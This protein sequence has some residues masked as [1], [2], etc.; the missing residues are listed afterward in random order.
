MKTVSNYDVYL[1]EDGHPYLKEKGRFVSEERY[2]NSPNKVAGLFRQRFSIHRKAEEYAYL[3]SLNHGSE[4]LGIFEISHGGGSCTYLTTREVMMRNLLCGA[5][6][7]I[8]VH[9]HPSG[10]VEPSGDDMEVYRRL[11]RAG[12]LMNVPISDFIIIGRGDMFSYM[13]HEML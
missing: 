12:S 3:L 13:E 11:K 8:V 1:D 9:N 5:T 6:H 4:V 2:Y 7:F 10:C